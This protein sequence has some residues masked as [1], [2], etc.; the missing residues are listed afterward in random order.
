M[1]YLVIIK[2]IFKSQLQYVSATILRLIISLLTFF[3]QVSLWS[4]LIASGQRTD[5]TVEEMIVYVILTMFVSTFT[6]GN[7]AVNLEPTI[8]DG[9]IANQLIKPI[10]FK[11]YCFSEVIGK[12]VYNVVTSTIPIMILGFIIYTPVLP[13]PIY[14]ILFIISIMLGC[15]IMLELTYIFGLLAFFTQRAWYINWYLNAFFTLFGGSVVPLWFY[16]NVLNR[17]SYFLP[18]RYISFEPINFFLQRTELSQ[19]LFFLVVPILWILVL[20]L[21]GNFVFR[22]VNEKLTINGG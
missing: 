16:P 17:I 5:T 14:S 2:K 10:S 15:M 4:A 1:V 18:F 19:S 6:S 21:I 20:I 9:S 13:K 12:N 7:I 22:L 3:I 8:R 11:Y